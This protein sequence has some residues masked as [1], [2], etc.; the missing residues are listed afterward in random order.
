MFLNEESMAPHSDFPVGDLRI[1]SA[2][3]IDCLHR[4]KDALFGGRLFIPDSI[5]LYRLLREANSAKEPL[6]SELTSRL[7]EI[8]AQRWRRWFVHSLLRLSRIKEAMEQTTYP[9]GLTVEEAKLNIDSTRFGVADICGACDLVA[10][11]RQIPSSVPNF[12]NVGLRKLL[13]LRRL[14]RKWTS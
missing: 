1:Q 5:W 6:R 3:M 9:S 14:K 12:Q 13:G 2:A 7:D 10:K 8:A 11:V 4:V